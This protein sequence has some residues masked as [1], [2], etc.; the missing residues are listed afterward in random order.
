[1]SQSELKTQI[2]NAMKTAINKWAILS[3]SAMKCKDFT[4]F[5]VKSFLKWMI[6]TREELQFRR[7]APRS[8]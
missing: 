6:Y 3:L 5:L 8:R 1:M 7:V 4:H 2:F